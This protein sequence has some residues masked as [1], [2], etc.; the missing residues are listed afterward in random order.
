L[1]VEDRL[2]QVLRG[3][4]ERVGLDLAAAGRHSAE[5]A[6]VASA[7]S[8]V[9]PSRGEVALAAL[10]LD[11]YYTSLESAFEMIARDL[12]GSLPSGADWHR[13]LLAQ[14]S[15]PGPAR[16]AV[17]RDTTAERLREVLRFR[18]FL[19]HAY[20]VDLDWSR[21]VDVAA[22]LTDLHLEATADL[23]AFRAFVATCLQ[24]ATSL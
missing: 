7:G 22:G 8:T 21:M 1:T 13:A 20:A 5:V 14:M 17:L 18:H 9:S 4:H 24:A 16:E 2:A 10:A 15:R 23:E 6:Q 19:R 11:R 3:L 12:D